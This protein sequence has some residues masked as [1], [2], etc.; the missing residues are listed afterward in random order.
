MFF[1][2]LHALWGLLL[3][4]ACERAPLPERVHFAFVIPLSVSPGAD[5]VARGDTLWLT[6]NFSDSLLDIRSNRRYRLPPQDIKIYTTVGFKHLVGAGQ[7]YEGAAARFRVVSRVG[8]LR[9]GGG[10]FSRL[11]LVHDGQHYQARIGIIPQ[12]VGVY[13]LSFFS[14]FDS[15]IGAGNPL[16][17]LRVPPDGNGNPRLAVLDDIYYVIN[18]GNTHFALQRQNNYVVSDKPGAPEGS[19]YYETKGTYTFAVR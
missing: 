13:A 1:R 14:S 12:A 3:L 6:A 7:F 18:D 15:P 19:V 11:E 17:F 2:P 8:Q 16:P 10:I 9:A 4:T 5:T